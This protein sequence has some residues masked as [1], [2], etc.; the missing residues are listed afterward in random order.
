MEAGVIRGKQA[1]L[2][3]YLSRASGWVT[4]AELAD[5]VG[6]TPRSIRSYVGEFKESD[7][8]RDVVE[9]SSQGYRLNGPAYAALL[10]REQTQPSDVE[11]PMAR[12]NRLLRRLL[13]EPAGIDVFG[14][15]DEAFVSE[16]TVDSDLARVRRRLDGSGLS[17]RRRGS[18]VV[19]DGSESDRRRL[20][21]QLFR[22]ESEQHLVTRGRIAAVFE[23]PNLGE[24][25]TQLVAALDVRGYFVNEYGINDVLLHVAIALDRTAHDRHLEPTAVVADDA[26]QQTMTTLDDLLQAHFDVLL[27]GAE[28]HQLAM[29]LATRVLA[30]R[31]VGGDA[32]EDYLDRDVI[33]TVSRIVDEASAQYA[34]DLR[35][36][37]FTVRLALHVQ[38]LLARAGDQSYSRNPLTRSIKTSYPLIYELAVYIASRLQRAA[39]ITVTDDEIAYIAMHVGAYLDQQSRRRDSVT[40]AL[41]CPGYYDIHRLLRDRIEAELG[42][43]LVVTTVLS[44]AASDLDSLDT[45]LVLTTIPTIAP[46]EGVVVIQPFLTD[47]DIDTVRTAIARVR[48]QRRRAR[49]K[50]QLLRYFDASLFF[51]NT[52][53]R[54]EFAMI[55]ML[56]ERLRVAGLV[57]GA[58]VDGALERERMSSTAFTDM[59]AVP[60]SMAMTAR[61]TAI[62]IVVNE[63]AMDWGG[64]RVNVI[65]FIAFNAD[66]R[67]SFQE[68]FDQFVEVFGD[69]EVVQNLTRKATGF[70]EFI[71]ELVHVFDS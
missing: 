58:Y 51:R 57:D 55:R 17:L 11:S 15:A 50:E 49:I 9:S 4:A 40:C 1:K 45:D 65:A 59:L 29:L 6:V 23:L 61:E 54:D 37:P 67:A 47:A 53:A 14:A 63:Q 2:L 70:P 39:G 34:I 43:D 13:D 60:H 56:G 24:F 30:P 27:D 16:S 25:A 21:S 42:Q 26:V 33:E 32:L 28:L 52:Y 22:D 36:G 71:D 20:L 8:S 31:G 48:R 44:D 62:A 3:D 19:L 64:S 66:E 41:I 7:A 69:R 18:I 5:H 10:S 12:A 46:R 68:V 38:N 35:D